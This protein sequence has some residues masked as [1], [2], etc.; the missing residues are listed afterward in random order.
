MEGLS[1]D[2]KAYQFVGGFDCKLEAPAMRKSVQS[3]ITPGAWHVD[4]LRSRKLHIVSLKNARIDNKQ[5]QLRTSTI[6][7]HLPRKGTVT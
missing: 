4:T 6:A 2:G 1:N 3:F 7:I 5:H